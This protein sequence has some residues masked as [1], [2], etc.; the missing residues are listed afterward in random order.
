MPLLISA[1]LIRKPADDR[2]APAGRALTPLRSA[3]GTIRLA[4]ARRLGHP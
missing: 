4:P 2:R 3:L 1:F